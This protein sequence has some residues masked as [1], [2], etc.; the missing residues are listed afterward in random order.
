MRIRCCML[1]CR[2]RCNLKSFASGEM[3]VHKDLPTDTT[4]MTMF[5]ERFCKLETVVS[6]KLSQRRVVS[7]TCCEC[8]R[9]C[10]LA[11]NLKPCFSESVSV[12]VRVSGK[13][14]AYSVFLDIWHAAC[15]ESLPRTK[16]TRARVRIF[17]DG[18]VRSR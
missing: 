8:T 13:R 4:S 1:V 17:V 14:C 15:G 6:R 7:N 9:I 5:G 11:A 2:D 12:R 3:L 16:G 10:L 18:R